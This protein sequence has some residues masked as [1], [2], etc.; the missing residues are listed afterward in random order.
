MRTTD[1]G[2]G[3]MAR[4]VALAAWLGAMARAAEA[5]AG[6]AKD[7]VVAAGAIKGLVVGADGK[8][9]A[10]VDVVVQPTAQRTRT[11]GDGTFLLSGIAPGD[12]EVLFRKLGLE[13]ATFTTN[14]V[15]GQQQEVKVTLAPIAKELDTVRVTASV[16]NEINGFVTDTLRHPIEGADVEIDGTE[17][18]MRTRADG[19]FLFLDIAPGR[20]MLRVRKLGYGQVRRS[21]QM[22]RQ[23]ERTISVVM[24]PLPLTLSPVEIIAQSGLSSRDSVAQVEFSIRRRMAGSQSDLMIRDE[25]AELGK[26]PLNFAIRQKAKGIASKELAESA[27]VLIDGQQPLVDAGTGVQLGLAGRGP[28]FGGGGGNS[29]P[30]SRGAPAGAGNFTVLQTLFADQVESIEIYPA[31]SELSGTACSRFPI[32]MP[33]CGCDAAR[34]PAIVVVWLRK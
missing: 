32:T 26:S 29:N 18:R 10:N 15:A 23:L 13:P 1:R 5:Q 9:I 34:S 16:F 8:P 6:G 2:W 17:H 28:S 4:V 19:R 3:R 30:A 11:K 24:T 27:C 31:G 25:L 20:Y 21:V 22:A 7:S 14:V 33:Q 12:Y